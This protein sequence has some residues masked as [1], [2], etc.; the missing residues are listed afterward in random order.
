MH[1]TE[2]L[3]C[4]SKEMYKY[5]TSDKSLKTLQVYA[6]KFYLNLLLNPNGYET[7]GRAV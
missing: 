2:H 5:E 4:T 3:V 7:I 1:D 6:L